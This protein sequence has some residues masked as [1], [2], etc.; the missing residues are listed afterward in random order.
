MLR[1]AP[2]W[3]LCWFACAGTVVATAAHA[4]ES[5]DVPSTVFLTVREPQ[6]VG[7]AGGIPPMGMREIVRQAFLIAARDELGLATRDSMLREEFPEKP[8]EQSVPFELFCRTRDPNDDRKLEYVL[9]RQGA[10][11]KPLWQLKFTVD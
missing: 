1:L 11:E 9:T 8:D 10:P 3:L 2:T 7:P 4:D 5:R 6:A